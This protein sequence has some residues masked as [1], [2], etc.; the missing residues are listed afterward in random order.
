ML[1]GV[2]VDREGWDESN[3]PCKAFYRLGLL[4]L[5][6]S[7]RAALLPSTLVRRG[8]RFERLQLTKVLPGTPVGLL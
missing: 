1:C 5:R 3:Q 8:E 4:S 2:G 7:C 6:Q